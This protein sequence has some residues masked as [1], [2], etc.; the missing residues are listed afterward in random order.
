MRWLTHQTVALGIGLVL[1]LPTTAVL[2]AVAGAV[3]PDVCDQRIAGTALTR[4]G[5]QKLF[6]SLHRGTTHWW[7]WWL[8]CL[9]AG[10][11]AV[12]PP[13]AKSLLTGLGL[14]GLSHVLLDM[15]TLRGVPLL[16]FGKEP[17]LSLSL[18][19]TGSL[20]EWLFLGAMTAFFTLL[21][22]KDLPAL[23]ARITSFLR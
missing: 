19:R 14:G 12:D 13:L 9:Y 7:G 11:T 8:L 4:L 5:R 2:A 16:P 21:L 6:K 1:H 18:C 23:S 3:F 20:G 22:W 10:W 17:R 15:L